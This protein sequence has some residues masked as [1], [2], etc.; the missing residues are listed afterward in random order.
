MSGWETLSGTA[1]ALQQSNIDTDQLIPARF[2]SQPRSAGYGGFL[3]HD[4]RAA[5]DGHPLGQHKPKVLVT[6]RNFGSG[7]SREAAVYALVDFGIKAVFAPSFGDIFMGNAVNN[8]LLAAQI[9]TDIASVLIAA[10]GEDA[11]A[12]QVDLRTGRATIAGQDVAFD[13]DP[14]SRQKLINGWDDIDMT[15]HHSEQIKAFRAA[16][17]AAHSWALPAT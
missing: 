16:R 13:L 15:L 5:Q 10:L 2:M 17:L 1:V 7:S 3:L 11:G 4:V 6:G 9:G 12:A 14:V 8:G